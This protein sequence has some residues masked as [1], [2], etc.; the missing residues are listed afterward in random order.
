MIGQSMLSARADELTGVFLAKGSMLICLLFGNSRP[1][2]LCQK[3]FRKMYG[4]RTLFE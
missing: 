1:Q 4:K 3:D 2:W